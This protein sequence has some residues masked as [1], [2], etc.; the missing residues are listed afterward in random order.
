MSNRPFDRTIFHPLERPLGDDINQL[1]SNF[2]QTFRFYASQLAKNSAG[3][4]QD[5]FL[6]N[7]FLVSAISPN[8]LSVTVSPGLGFQLQVG[9]ETAIDGVI[10]YNDLEPYKPI[11]LLAAQTFTVPTAPAAPNSRIDIIE[12]K[13]IRISTDPSTRQVLD[14]N[15]GQFIPEQENKTSA[16]AVDGR[17]AVVAA[18]GASTAPLSYRTGVAAASPVAPAVTTGYIKIAEIVVGSDVTVINATNITDSR[19][20]PKVVKLHYT[21][22]V[23]AWDQLPTSAPFVAANAGFVT[24]PSGTNWQ[25]GIGTGL[26]DGDVIE[27]I[28]VHWNQ[29]DT[30]TNNV[31]STVR[32]TLVDLEANTADTS[33]ATFSSVTTTAHVTANTVVTHDHAVAAP[34]KYP[35][36]WSEGSAIGVQFT[37]SR[38]SSNTRILSIVMTVRRNF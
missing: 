3:T 30:V 5:G 16:W 8:A 10:G 36:V 31:T 34:T 37:H 25:M 18:G 2:D 24:I 4:P 27:N 12:A 23:A 14:L 19:L 7:G 33:A 32:Y 1:Q 13:A 28:E 29:D 11:P 26:Q 20:P 35:L 9:T 21:P 22:I 15:L 38:A 6:A 17:A